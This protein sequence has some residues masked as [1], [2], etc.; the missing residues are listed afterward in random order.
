MSATV[1]LRIVHLFP[2]VLR[3]YGDAGNVMTIVRRAEARSIPTTV[4]HVRVGAK[5]I[6]RADLV[7][8][9]G[10]QDREQATVAR[11]LERLGDQLID[12]VADGAA[13]LAIC[14]GYQNL[15]VRYRTTQG[16]DLW[17]PGLLP[18]ST[19]GRESE[20]RLVGPVVARVRDEVVNLGRSVPLDPD[21]PRESSVV[22]FENHAARTILEA[23]ARP[24]A[25]IEI[26]HG[27]NGRGRNRGGRAA[28]GRGRPGRASDRV[29]PPRTPAAAKPAH[30]GCLDRVRAQSAESTIRAPCAR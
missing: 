13:L 14:G 15:G 29:V 8:I 6:P 21:P 11:E 26:G 22:G 1:R 28:A 7:V 20:R 10:G 27:N 12:L 4:A 19:V 23:G 30:R 9:G 25:T 16:E 5:R 3:V 2:D 24:F 18:V 17:C